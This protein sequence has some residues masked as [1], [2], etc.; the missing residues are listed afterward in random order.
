MTDRRSKEDGIIVEFV[1]GKGYILYHILEW[2]TGY[3]II[4][5]LGYTRARE[6]VPENQRGVL[7]ATC[8]SYVDEPLSVFCPIN[9][10]FEHPSVF[11]YLPIR[12]SRKRF[13]Y[14][15]HVSPKIKADAFK[16]LQWILSYPNPQ[17]YSQHF[18]QPSSEYSMYEWVPQ[19]NRSV[20]I[21]GLPRVEANDPSK[22]SF[23]SEH[24]D[25]LTKAPVTSILRPKTAIY[26]AETS[27]LSP[28]AIHGEVGCEMLDMY[29]I[30][31]WADR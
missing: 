7:L 20:L 31:T 10:W 18:N 23:E 26:S 13:T 16:E 11:R 30:D 12:K 25:M 22:P 29:R 19:F 21:P 14:R 24:E 3:R 4:Y 27:V 17:D 2:G 15:I 1:M 8:R 28:R 6:K 9:P 5:E